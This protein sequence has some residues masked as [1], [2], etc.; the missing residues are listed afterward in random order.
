MTPTNHGWE[1][2][3]VTVTHHAVRRYQERVLM[4]PRESAQTTVW[5]ILGDLVGGKLLADRDKAS[6]YVRAPRPGRH[7]LVM[8]GLTVMTVL[9]PDAVAGR[10]GAVLRFKSGEYSRYDRLK[11]KDQRDHRYHRADRWGAD[12]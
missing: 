9:P 6:R 8:R 1:H 2:E 4:G 12:E 3:G 7:V 11:R 5:R 10:Q